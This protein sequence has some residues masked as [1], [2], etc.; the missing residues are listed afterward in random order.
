MPKAICL[1][2]CLLGVIV[3]AV[4]TFA[5]WEATA[6]LTATIPASIT[7][8]PDDPVVNTSSKADRFPSSLPPEITMGV[9]E[10]ER[11]TTAIDQGLITTVQTPISS[12]HWHEGSKKITRK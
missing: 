4:L 9:S 3:A 8:E 5:D 10:P 1:A 7:L 2:I 12:W 6:D 11:V